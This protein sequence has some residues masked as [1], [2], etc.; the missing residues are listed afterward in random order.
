VDHAGANLKTIAAFFDV[1]GTLFTGH[2]W[3][4]MVD[5]FRRIRGVWP[6]RAFWYAHM[7]SY[8]LRRLKLI[9]EEQFRGPWGAHLAWLAKGWDAD[10]LCGLYDY[11]A[12]EYV[13]P[14]RR[15]D[16]IGLL[17][18]HNAQGHLTVLVSTGFTDMV[19]AI[20]RT[21][22]AQVAVGSDLK[23]KDG[24]C[25]GSIV[26]PIV[27]GAQKGSEAKRRLASLGYDVD[28][29][30]SF[31]YAD[32]ITDMGLFDIVGNPRPVYPDAELA[33]V[34]KAKGWPIFGGTR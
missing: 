15:E 6:V 27:I 11:I 2:V 13:T 3:R 26:P 16:T 33:Q 25:A 29:A 32:S 19:A 20:G 7:P 21:I 18:E 4:G 10:Q 17:A 22:G 5:Y 28:Y 30:N 34:A 23:M 24:H 12:H 14:H 8:L 9:S 31:A 1:D